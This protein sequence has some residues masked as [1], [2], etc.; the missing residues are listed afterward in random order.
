[1]FLQT[2]EDCCEAGGGGSNTLQ[3]AVAVPSQQASTDFAQ[4]LWALPFKQRVELCIGMFR[5]LGPVVQMLQEHD[6]FGNDGF[7]L[8]TK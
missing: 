2:Q 7:A 8:Q 4:Y 6:A 1:M 5:G 3:P